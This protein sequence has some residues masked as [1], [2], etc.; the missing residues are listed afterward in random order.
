MSSYR[1]SASAIALYRRYDGDLDGLSRSVDRH[2]EVSEDIW[3]AI[4]DLRQRAAIVK[5]GLGSAAFRQCFAIDYAACIAD[6]EARVEFQC[7]I[8]SD[9]Q[10]SVK[11]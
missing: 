1:I 6:D 8:D 11:S 9:L 7:L 3:R 2:A 4:D 10:S 5:K